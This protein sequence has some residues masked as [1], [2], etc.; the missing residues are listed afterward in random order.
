MLEPCLCSWLSL[1]HLDSLVYEEQLQAWMLDHKF[2]VPLI[3]ERHFF[4]TP[5]VL[6]FCVTTVFASPRQ[7]RFEVMNGN[8]RINSYPPD[9]EIHEKKKCEQKQ[10]EAG[11][12][13][14]TLRVEGWNNE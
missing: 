2:W 14:Y 12:Y 8:A 6:N 4:W 9:S 1:Q 5:C 10:Q 13:R 11:L 3:S 7:I